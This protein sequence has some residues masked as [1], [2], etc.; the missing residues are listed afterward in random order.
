MVQH[1]LL[2]GKQP[3]EWYGPQTVS[4]VLRE[5]VAAHEERTGRPSLMVLVAD[6]GTIYTDDVYK[7]CSAHTPSLTDAANSNA[8]AVAS[9]NKDASH[10]SGEGKSDSF[11]PLLHMSPDDEAQ[12]RAQREPWERGLLILI[13]V[14]LGLDKINECYAAGAYCTVSACPHLL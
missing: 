4:H 6:E 2:R 10:V 7:M 8:D 5:M 11:D 1:G 12:W 3:G 9:N 14:R 13:P